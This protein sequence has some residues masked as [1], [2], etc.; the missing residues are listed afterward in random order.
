MPND[1]KERK[2][3][4]INLRQ[5]RTR[6]TARERG[7][8]AVW[9]GYLIYDITPLFPF[10]LPLLLHFSLPL[11][12]LR[13]SARA[14]TIFAPSP[15]HPGTTSP[16]PVPP[17]LPFNPEGLFFPYDP[18]INEAKKCAK[19]EGGAPVTTGSIANLCRRACKRRKLD[20]LSSV[21]VQQHGFLKGKH[22]RS[23]LLHSS[24]FWLLPVPSR[25]SRNCSKSFLQQ[26]QKISP[27]N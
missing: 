4:K 21:R 12:S 8:D 6:Q 18:T 27:I 9:E 26:P 2:E 11:T 3:Q 19:V 22:L 25:T 10:S 17:M 1:G 14:Q 23:S 16:P 24:S 5:R 20:S 15:P 7:P 13:V